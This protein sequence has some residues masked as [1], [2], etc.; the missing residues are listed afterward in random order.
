[1]AAGVCLIFLIPYCAENRDSCDEEIRILPKTAQNEK[2]ESER[3]ESDFEIL[4]SRRS[5]MT[6]EGS[7]KSD[8]DLFSNRSR[9]CIFPCLPVR[10]RGGIEEGKYCKEEQENVKDDDQDFESKNRYNEK[11]DSA[12]DNLEG[13]SYKM[14]KPESPLEKMSVM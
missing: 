1:M 10:S 14:P 7:D 2:N 3:R 12:K 11:V 8:S 4:K 5:K 6:I 9:F 13:V